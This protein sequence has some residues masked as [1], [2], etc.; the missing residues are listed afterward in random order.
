MNKSIE[1]KIEISGQWINQ[2]DLTMSDKYIKW[3]HIANNPGKLR[4]C[5]REGNYM[6]MAP[7]FNPLPS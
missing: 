5:G 3:L 1:F 7:N 4:D 6:Y 2:Y